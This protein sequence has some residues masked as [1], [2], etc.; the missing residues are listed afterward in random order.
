MATDIASQVEKV[1]YDFHHEEQP[2]KGATVYYF[3]RIVSVYQLLRPLSSIS[4]RLS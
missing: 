1:V 4:N 3:H 2:I